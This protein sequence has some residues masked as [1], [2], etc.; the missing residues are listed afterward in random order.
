MKKINLPQIITD[1]LQAISNK[2]EFF[3][4]QDAIVFD[5]TRKEI[6]EDSNKIALY[7]LL[8]DPE[9]TYTPLQNTT[10]EDGTYQLVLFIP[11]KYL[12]DIQDLLNTFVNSLI[13]KYIK[14]DEETAILNVDKPHLNSVDP[15]NLKE[16]S[17]NDARFHFT[18]E[19]YGQ[20]LISV[21]YNGNRN[22]FAFGNDI[23]ITLNANNKAEELNCV[24][25]GVLYAE[26]TNPFQFLSKTTSETSGSG[27]AVTYTLACLVKREGLLYD[28]VQDITLNGFYNYDIT[29]KVQSL[30]STNTFNVIITKLVITANLGE[31]LQVDI[32]LVRGVEV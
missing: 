16:L 1:A 11:I 30:N 28:I 24:E 8:S 21:Y 31:M 22:N 12:T 6:Q 26:N 18:T 25:L 15:L 14:L 7:G 32:D 20:F 19:E 5:T 2:Y 27:R 23:K 13:G 17:D 29:A 4:Y 9:I 10:I 3:I